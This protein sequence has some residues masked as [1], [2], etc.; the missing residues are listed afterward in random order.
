MTIYD[1]NGKPIEITDLDT[2]IELAEAYKEYHHQ[3]EQYYEMDK[4][5]HEYW[6]DIYKKLL[7]LKS[8]NGN[9]ANS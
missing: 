3:D 5:L 2:A 6:S 8:A 1:L 7:E 4:R 9:T